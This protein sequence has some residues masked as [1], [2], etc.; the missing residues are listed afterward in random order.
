MYECIANNIP[1]VLAG[2]VRDDGP[3]PDVVTDI[4]EA[5]RKYKQL[6]K[7][8]EMVLMLST[9]LHSIAVGNMLPASVKVVAVDISQPVVTKLLDRGTNQAIGIVTDVGAFLP[10]VIQHLEQMKNDTKK[11]K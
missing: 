3:I 10:M 9:M 11:T 5:Q 7:D 2:S 1:F 4:V 6:L 8:A